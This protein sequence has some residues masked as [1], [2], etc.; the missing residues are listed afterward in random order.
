MLPPVDARMPYRSTLGGSRQATNAS[1]ERMLGPV[2][3]GL[4]V[5]DA[6]QHPRTEQLDRAERLLAAGRVEI[7]VEDARAKLL[8]DR[9]DLAEHRLRAAGDQRPEL[10]ALLQRAHLQHPP[11]LVRLVT[12]V[13]ARPR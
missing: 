2:R 9:A 5:A 6:R 4:P 1:H 13:V 12:A 8:L 11:A 7:Q 10:D 3:P